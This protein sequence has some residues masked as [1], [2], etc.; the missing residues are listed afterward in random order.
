MICDPMTNGMCPELSGLIAL[1][2]IITLSP[3]SIVPGIL[4]LLTPRPLPTGVAFLSGWVAG[5]AG[6]TAVFLAIYSS[7]GGLNGAGAAWVPYMRIA[8]GAALI[9]FGVYRW[10]K[11]ERPAYAA[12]FMRSLTSIGPGRA[13]VAAAVLVV[14]NPKVLLTCA[15]AGLMIGAAGLRGGEARAGLAVFTA[16]AASSVA[17]PVLA[18]ALAG[19]KLKEP[20]SVL[21]NWLEARHTAI[22]AVVLVL[23]GMAVLYRGI[24]GL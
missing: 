13:A 10:L 22:V 23:I 18:F 12:A 21:K 11:R 4:M 7:F 2:L 24:H 20:L 19:E 6:L 1:A 5:I 17:L 8:I 15:A 9:A 14:V 16:V 3:L